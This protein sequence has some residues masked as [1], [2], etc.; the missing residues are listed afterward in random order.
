MT[1]LERIDDAIMTAQIMVLYPEGY[2]FDEWEK[3]AEYLNWL[4]KTYKI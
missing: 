3:M 4:E 2:T 1:I